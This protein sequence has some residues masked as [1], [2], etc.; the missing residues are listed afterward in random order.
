MS[1][2]KKYAV[3]AAIIWGANWAGSHGYKVGTA[4]SWVTGLTHNAVSSVANTV[5]SSNVGK[6]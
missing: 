4:V 2:I 1:T 5:E 3:W 6:K